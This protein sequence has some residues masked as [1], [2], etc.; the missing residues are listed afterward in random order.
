MFY[1]RTYLRNCKLDRHNTKFE[2]RLPVT[3]KTSWVVQCTKYK[4]KMAAAAILNIH[5]NCH[6]SVAIAHIRP[7]VYGSDGRSYKML[8]MFFFF[9]HAFSEVPRPIAAK[10]CHTIENW[11][12]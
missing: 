6:N 4:F 12:D 10:L 9:R 3:K 8:V 7:P 2:H 11:L 5:I 1:R